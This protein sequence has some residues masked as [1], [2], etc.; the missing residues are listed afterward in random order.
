MLKPSSDIEGAIEETLQAL[1]AQGVR[2]P[3][4]AEVAEHLKQCPDLITVLEPVIATAQSELPDAQLSL[5]VYHDPEI[6]DEHLVLYARF[7]EYDWNSVMER[8][9]NAGVRCA[10]MLNGQKGWLLLTTDFKPAE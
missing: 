2:L 5:E 10:E 6:E 4:R 3:N 7:S 9:H 1:S 8:V